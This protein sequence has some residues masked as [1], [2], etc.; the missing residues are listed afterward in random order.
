TRPPPTRTPFPYT[1][2][3]RSASSI[4]W[5][6]DSRPSDRVEWLCKSKFSKPR[7]Y[8]PGMEIRPVRFG[9]ESALATRE[10]LRRFDAGEGSGDPR[11][12]EHTSELQS[13]DHLVCR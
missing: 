8:H 6:G 5:V 4:S 3:F 10:L 2:L 1:T 12:E 7:L 13:P 9:G 11:S